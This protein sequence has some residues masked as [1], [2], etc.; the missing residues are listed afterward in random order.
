MTPAGIPPNLEGA[1]LPWPL[2]PTKEG[3]LPKSEAFLRGFPSF[4]ILEGARD[5]LLFSWLG[6]MV[7]NVCLRLSILF[8]CLGLRQ[9]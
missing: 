9:G 7:P 4:V 6:E 1:L 3:L 2:P 8:C 5:A